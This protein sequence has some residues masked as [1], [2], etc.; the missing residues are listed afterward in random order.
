M[1]MNKRE[2][3]NKLREYGWPAKEFM[4]RSGGSLLLRGLRQE[5]AD[6][7]LCVSPALA[8][9][10]DLAHCPRDEYGTFVPMEN[11]S[12]TPNLGEVPFDLVEG[13]QCETLESVLALKKRLLREKDLR[14]IERIKKVLK[15]G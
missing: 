5:T 4:I 13:W 15:K 10:L 14:D 1:S 2:F 8:E 11:V 6:F 7:D 12:M 3:L 9:Q